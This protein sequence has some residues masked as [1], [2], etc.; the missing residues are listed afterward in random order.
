M[1]SVYDLCSHGRVNSSDHIMFNPV[2]IASFNVFVIDDLHRDLWS[3]R[4]ATRTSQPG[5]R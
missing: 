5:P 4:L 2:G 1:K 3:Y